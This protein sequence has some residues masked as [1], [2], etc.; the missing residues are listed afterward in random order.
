[1]G[2]GFAYKT[3]LA[4]YLVSSSSVNDCKMKLHIQLQCG[5]C[6]TLF[7]AYAPTFQANEEIDMT[8]YEDTYTTIVS[9]LNDNKLI[10]SDDF[11]ACIGRDF[12]IHN[13][14][15]W[16]SL[17]K[18]NANCLKLFELCSE[19]T[20]TICNTLFQKKKI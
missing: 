17:G 5:W 3:T 12:V 6:V 7:S 19:I 1:M 13:L 9:M 11:N 16:Y 20:L 2:A 4:K 10:I 18:V 14:L 15:G 8:F